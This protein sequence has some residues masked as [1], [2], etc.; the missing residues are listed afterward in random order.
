[1]HRPSLVTMTNYR[2]SRGIEVRVEDA[3]RGWHLLAAVEHATS[4]MATSRDW[5]PDFFGFVLHEYG[6]DADYLPSNDAC[7][8]QMQA[9]VADHSMRTYDANACWEFGLVT[10]GDIDT[11]V[12]AALRIGPNKDQPLLEVAV[13]VSGSDEDTVLAAFEGLRRAVDAART[14]E[15]SR[16]RRC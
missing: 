5:T 11:S 7:V 1:M 13:S 14:G 3:R 12:D 10:P 15:A 2:H 4:D 9:H 6:E 16:T 8:A